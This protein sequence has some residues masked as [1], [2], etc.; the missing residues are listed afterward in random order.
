MKVIKKVINFIYK[1]T[2]IVPIYIYY[3]ILIINIL[4]IYF[5][6]N[7]YPYGVFFSE[8]ISNVQGYLFLVTIF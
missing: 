3:N 6:L 2:Y 7:S 5:I 8:R 1:S 4:Y